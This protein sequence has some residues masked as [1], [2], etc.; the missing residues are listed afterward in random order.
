VRRTQ[1]FIP[2]AERHRKPLESSAWLAISKF[3]KTRLA[4]CSASASS[5]IPRI[6]C[7]RSTGSGN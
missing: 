2:Q 4:K 5:H 3:Y 7:K 6:A 1:R